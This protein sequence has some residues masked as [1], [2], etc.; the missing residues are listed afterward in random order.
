MRP[1]PAIVGALALAVTLPWAVAA[2]EVVVYRCTAADGAVTLQNG[3]RCPRGQRE[4]RRVVEVPTSRATPAAL[5]A[6][7]ATPAPITPMAGTTA[8]PASTTSPAGASA[9]TSAAAQS[10]PTDTT[11][12]IEMGTAPAP[13]V[14]ACRTWDGQRYYGDSERPEPRCAPLETVGLDRRSET[15]AQACEMRADV[16][17][18]VIESARCD[19]WAERLRLAEGSERFGGAE[20][21]AA[22]RAEQARLRTLLAGTVCAR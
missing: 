2:P 1:V 6:P 20:A 18:P 13:P 4:E 9:S 5:P 21:S 7:V 14:F 17:E 11:P 22:A 8:S 16:C 15:A 12:T 19:A 3:R 10:T